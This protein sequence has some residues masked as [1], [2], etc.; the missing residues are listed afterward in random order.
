MPLIDILASLV[1]DYLIL[2]EKGL[3][4]GLTHRVGRHSLPPMDIMAEVLG[5][6]CNGAALAP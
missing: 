2:E 1:A 5:S 4:L 6:I 3:C